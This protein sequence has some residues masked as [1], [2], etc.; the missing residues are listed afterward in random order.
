MQN[1]QATPS[2]EDEEHRDDYLFLSS[3]PWVSF[4]GFQHAMSYH[5]HDSVPRITWG[6]FIQEQGRIK[7][8]LSVQAHHGVVDGQHIGSYFQQMEKWGGMLEDWE[9]K[10]SV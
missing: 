1:M 10:R 8:P 5:P 6:K 4:T 2:I 3:F 9:G 7:M